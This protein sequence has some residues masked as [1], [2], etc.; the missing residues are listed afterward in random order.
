[1]RQ[2]AVGSS[3]RRG[4]SGRKPMDDPGPLQVQELNAMH[5]AQLEM[6]R[7]AF[8]HDRLMNPASPPVPKPRKGRNLT[9]NG[10][11]LGVKGSFD[12]KE[13]ILGSSLKS[14]TVVAFGR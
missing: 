13:K 7:P 11:T 4:N 1:M 2:S 9:A 3:S 5:E 14:P 12:A 8:D 6:D 10:M